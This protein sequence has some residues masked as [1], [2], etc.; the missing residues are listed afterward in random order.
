MLWNAII[1][2]ILLAIIHFDWELVVQVQTWKNSSCDFKLFNCKIK[3]CF[4]NLSVGVL[5][6]ILWEFLLLGFSNSGS[7]FSLVGDYKRLGEC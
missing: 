5:K 2:H 4:S 3:M 7:F 6:I 1:I